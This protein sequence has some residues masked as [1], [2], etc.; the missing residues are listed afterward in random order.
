MLFNFSADD[1][2][3]NNITYT[4]CINGTE[5]STGIIDKNECKEVEVNLEDGYYT[6]EIKIQDSQGNTGSSG[7]SDLYVDTEAR[8][9]SLISPEDRFIDTQGPLNFS[10]TADDAFTAQYK[11]QN[12]TY[13]VDLDGEPLD[14]LGSGTMRPGECIQTQ[15][16]TNLSEGAH[17][18]SVY[19]ED[20]AGNNITSDDRNFYLDKKGL[21]VSLVSP[22]NEYASANPKFN[23]RVSG[24]TGLPFNYKL[25]IDGKEVKSTCDGSENNTLT[26]GEDFAN[27]YSIIS[28]V[29]DG[30][31]MT[32]TVKVTDCAGN[33]YEPEP[34]HFSLDTEAPVR[35]ANLSVRMRLGILSGL[36]RTTL[37]DCTLAGMQIPQRILHLRLMMSLLAILSL[38]LLRTWRK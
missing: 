12:L 8:V 3:D 4:L 26:V 34:Y 2:F 37:P 23:F 6:W 17:Y 25:L 9:V 35:V 13:E 16:I 27:D 33:S 20:Q 21:K 5:K 24:G 18:W 30:K 29:A 32:W 31:D 10:F 28:K 7:S 38:T 22:N 14:G 1:Q 11:D 19:V 36:I 15:D